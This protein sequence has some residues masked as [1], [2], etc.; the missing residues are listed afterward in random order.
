MPS[1]P[2]PATVSLPSV[3]VDVVPSPVA[4]AW[5][6]TAFTSR[7]ADSETPLEQLMSTL[8]LPGARLCGRLTVTTNWFDW[9]P[10][11]MGI[12][13][14]SPSVVPDS[15][16]E[17]AG[18]PAVPEAHEATNVV[19]VPGADGFG[20]TFTFGLFASADRLWSTPRP[21]ASAAGAALESAAMVSP[22]VAVAYQTRRMDL[23]PV[24]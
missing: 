7:F 19:E 24:C 6:G 2:S 22:A 1:R 18:P 16:A 17:L 12:C 21:L 23:P 20:V 5:P 8:K 3:A 10:A 14:A 11:C 15:V 9:V 13:D 4:G